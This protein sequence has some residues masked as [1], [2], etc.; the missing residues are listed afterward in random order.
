LTEKSAKRGSWHVSDI[1]SRYK[2]RW[3]RTT[4]F[5]KGKQCRRPAES[6]YAHHQQVKNSPSA[7]GDDHNVS[8]E[9]LASLGSDTLDCHV[10]IRGLLLDE[11]DGFL[12]RNNFATELCDP[13]Q[14][15]SGSTTSLGPAAMRV[16]VALLADEFSELVSTQ[17]LRESVN[18]ILGLLNWCGGDIESQSVRLRFGT[19]IVTGSVLVIR[20]DDETAP[21]LS[22]ELGAP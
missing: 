6:V 13:L 11:R 4:N 3:L 2:L 8:V 10:S 14:S 16:P 9:S 19:V 15:N 1:P 20:D 5:R 21:V 18:D 17:V 7:S 22:V 12:G